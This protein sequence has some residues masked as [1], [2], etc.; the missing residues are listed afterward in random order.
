MDTRKVRTT[1][2]MSV[3]VVVEGETNEPSNNIL[4]NKNTEAMAE[5]IKIAMKDEYGIGL[6]AFRYYVIQREVTE[7]K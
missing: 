4:L 1:I 2:E 5:D 7:L 3:L 6:M